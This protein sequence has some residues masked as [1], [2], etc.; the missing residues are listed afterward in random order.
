MNEALRPERLGLDDIVLSHLG[1]VGFDLV[2]T[3]LW[4]NSFVSS[5]SRAIESLEQRLFDPLW[6]LD[7]FGWQAH[8]APA[9]EALRALPYCEVTRVS[10]H[11]VVVAERRK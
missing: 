8:V 2:S 5:P 1:E 4:E 7:D 3:V 11:S 6:D 9:L 10:R